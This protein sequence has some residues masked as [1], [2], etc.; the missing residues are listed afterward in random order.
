[1]AVVVCLRPV[2]ETDLA[3]LT[4]LLLDAEAAG[5]WQWFGYRLQRAHDVECERQDNGLLGSGQ[6][7]LSVWSDEE[8][9][10]WVTWLPVARSSAAFE[11]GIALFPE[12]RGH[13][14]GTEAQRQLV[15]YLF[16]NTP[17]HRLEAGTEVDNVAEQ[18]A[19]EKAGFRREGVRRGVTFRAGGWRDDVRYGLTR[20][21]L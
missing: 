3:R 15:A 4:Q 16:S 20:D 19:L 7:Y 12:H 10:G 13:G 14:V 5:E 17:V 18:R 11:I 21:D 8:L 2:Q 1:M 9:A 6:S